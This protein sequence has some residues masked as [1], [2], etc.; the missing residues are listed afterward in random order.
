MS[1]DA[2][3]LDHDGVIVTLGDRTALSAA[4]RDALEAVGV[5]DPAPDA[6]DT[7]SV[8]VSPT[9]LD[10]VSD[11]YGLDPDDLWRARDDGVRDALLA[12]TRAGRKTPYDD[13]NALVDLGVPTGI[14]SNNQTR[15]VEFVL[16]HYDLADHFGTVHARAPE[17]SSLE[18]KKPQ[19]TYLEDAMADL[20]VEN[21]LYVGDSESDVEAGQRAGL[22]VAFLRRDHNADQPLDSTPDYELM[23]LDEVVEILERESPKLQ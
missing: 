15:I 2:L 18:R 5:A 17:R 6:V 12:E 9:E 14:V 21:P 13:V 19:P 4:A 7:L 8:A 20:A 16:D 23:G 22:D 1:Y 3:L 11:R 10:A